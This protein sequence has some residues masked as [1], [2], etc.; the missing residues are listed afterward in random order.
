MK[1]LAHASA[2]ALCA[3]TVATTADAASVGYPYNTLSGEAPLVIGHRGAPAYLPENTIGGNALAA[4]MGADFV[5]TDVMMT[6]DNVLIA[7][8]DA[9]LDRTTDVEEVLGARN[10]GYAVADYTYDE[11]RQLTVQPTGT[12]DTTY[13]GFTPTGLDPYRVSTFADMLDALTAYNEA[14]GTDV[15]ML[16]EGKYSDD[17]AT[18]RAVIETL[19]EKGYDTPEKSAV[20]SFDFEN[21]RDYA[22]LLQAAGVDM[23]IAQLGVGGQVDDTW[24]V[25]ETESFATLAGYTD[26]VALYADYTSEALIKAAHDLGLSVYAWTFRPEDMDDAFDMAAPFLDWGLDGFITDNPDYILEAVNAYGGTIAP[27]PLPAALPLLAFGM[28]GLAG[29]GLKRRRS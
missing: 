6:K 20:Q 23:G 29:F 26:T 28:A 27:V 12:G 7:M 18:S 9:T 1:T 21:V 17:A 4:D 15:G 25:S 2:V 22:D 14:N 19:I 8:H 3:C 5:E 10:G 11:I 13:P 24:Y 16:T